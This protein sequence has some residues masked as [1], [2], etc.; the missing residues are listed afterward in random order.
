MSMYVL[1]KNGELSERQDLINKKESKVYMV[2]KGA[3]Q[4][5][6]NEIIFYGTTTKLNRLAKITIN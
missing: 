3:L 4:V 2:P 1:D 5:S 6:D